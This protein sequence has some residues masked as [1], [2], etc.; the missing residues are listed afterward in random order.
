MSDKCFYRKRLPHLVPRYGTFFVT[1]RLYNSIPKAIAE[2]INE[3]FEILTLE[4]KSRY[5]GSELTEK[6]DELNWLKFEEIEYI[7]DRQSKEVWMDNEC[8]KLVAREI[9]K[10]DGKYYD[11]LAY[12]IM[13][14]HV[15]ILIDLGLQVSY[16]KYTGLDKIMQYIKGASARY[17]NLYLGKTGS[18]WD[19]E[20]YDVFIRNNSMLNNILSYIAMNPVKARIVEDWDKYEYTYI[21]GEGL[22]D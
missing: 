14:N 3:K 1:F 2:K 19:L 10:H 17:C 21:K 16:E 15:H 22:V 20:S 9:T 4:L 8:K 13:S 11:L 12:C 5:S 18:F 7:H 6:L